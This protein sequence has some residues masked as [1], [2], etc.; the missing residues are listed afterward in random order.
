MKVHT[1]SSILMSLIVAVFAAE[2]PVSAHAQ[3]RGV[4]EG[5]EHGCSAIADVEESLGCRDDVIEIAS[6]YL[7]S[8]EAVGIDYVPELPALLAPDAKRWINRSRVYQAPNNDGRE[9]VL[10]G[11]TNEPVCT[12]PNKR[13]IVEGDAQFGKAAADFDAFC[14]GFPHAVIREYFLIEDGLIKEIEVRFVQVS[15]PTTAPWPCL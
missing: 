15:C 7:D 2:A 1:Q 8:I 10:A 11:V 12:F 6:A 3:M 5:R 14:V 13:W 9:A 4:P